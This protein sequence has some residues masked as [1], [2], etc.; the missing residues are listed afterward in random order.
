MARQTIAALAAACGLALILLPA[1]V[2]LA[3]SAFDQVLKDYQS[4]GQIDQCAHSEQSLRD[5]QHQIPNDI[6]QYAPDFPDALSAALRQRAAGT[7]DKTSSGS[8][9]STTASASSGSTGGSGGSSAPSSGGSSAK[10][11]PTPS[12]KPT[13]GA[14]PAPPPVA[15]AAGGTLAASIP[16]SAS[17]SEAGTPLPIILLAILGGLLL[18]IGLVVWLARF[19]GWGLDRWAPALHTLREA[20]YRSEN[21]ISEFADWARRG[22]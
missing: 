4:D 21:A 8:G 19:M 14:P 13:A 20:G 3:D 6:E 2:A 22:R 10:S 12:G 16:A 5:A 1:S 15:K 18:V 9:T 17:A 11:A 7:C